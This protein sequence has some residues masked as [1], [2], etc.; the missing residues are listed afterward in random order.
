MSEGEVGSL[1]NKEMHCD[2]SL[3][4]G[5]LII[6]HAILRGKDIPWAQAYAK[7]FYAKIPVLTPRNYIFQRSIT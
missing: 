7:K 2:E 6:Q 1:E 4:E 5:N 3:Q